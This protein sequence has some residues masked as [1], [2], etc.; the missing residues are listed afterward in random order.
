MEEAGTCPVRFLS[1]FTEAG[2]CR[3]RTMEKDEGLGHQEQGALLH[4]HGLFPTMDSFWVWDLNRY[5]SFSYYFLG[6]AQCLA[7]MGP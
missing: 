5:A 7:S 4:I 6:V 3:L 2:A 1:G